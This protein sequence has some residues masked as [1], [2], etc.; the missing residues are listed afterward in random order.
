MSQELKS[1]EEN[2]SVDKTLQEVNSVKSIAFVPTR[3]KP[4]TQQ[5]KTTS[6]KLDDQK[7]RDISSILE[8]DT[9]FDQKVHLAKKLAGLVS[10]T[11][12]FP[13]RKEKELRAEMVETAKQSQLTQSGNTKLKQPNSKEKGK[14]QATK[15]PNPMH[16]LDSYKDLQLKKKTLAK[17]KAELGIGKT[18]KDDERVK[19]EIQQLEQAKNTYIN[20]AKKLGKT[21]KN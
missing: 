7:F 5:K 21:G 16:Q 4:N 6:K 8:F 19:E 17:R 2:T 20:D 12:T 10:A 14:D 18:V 15:K 3:V 1:T 9:S 11:L 13:E